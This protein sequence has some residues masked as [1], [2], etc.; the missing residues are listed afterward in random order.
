MQLS[1]KVRKLLLALVATLTITGTVAVVSSPA[2]A[3][4]RT[5]ILISNDS[6]N[7]GLHVQI[8][9]SPLSSF[10]VTGGRDSLWTPLPSQAG[11]TMLVAITRHSTGERRAVGSFQ[12]RPNQEQDVRVS[13]TWDAPH[14]S[15]CTRC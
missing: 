2:Q 6:R 14:W 8:L 10:V 12:Y 9:G 15:T 11:Q 3:A 7:G 4:A 5:G 1:A 13:G